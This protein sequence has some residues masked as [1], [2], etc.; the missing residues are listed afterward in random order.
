MTEQK[1]DIKPSR[2]ERVPLSP[3]PGLP[4]KSRR[5]TVVFVPKKTTRKPE[6]P[7]APEPKNDEQ[8]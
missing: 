8:A 5:T 2:E 6:E 1:D 3:Y 7:P 4:S